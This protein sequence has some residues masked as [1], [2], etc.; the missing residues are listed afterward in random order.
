MPRANVILQSGETQ[1]F[2]PFPR[3]G[4]VRFKQGKSLGQLL[5]D[6]A[7]VRAKNL[8]NLRALNLIVQTI[9]TAPEVTQPSAP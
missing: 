5:D 2:P 8:S 1:P 7:A 3:D 6:F 9:S 4:Y